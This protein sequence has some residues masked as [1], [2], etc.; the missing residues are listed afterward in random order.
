[1]A[2][3]TNDFE[4]G[5]SGTAVS[6]AN[7]AGGPDTQWDFVQIGAGA[8]NAYD[9]TRSAHGGLSVQLATPATA[10]SAYL[11]WSSTG[12]LPG[13]AGPTNSMQ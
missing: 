7:S 12:H 8:T 11:Q 9:N 1:M 2:Q 10:T 6:T 5:S 3:V 4:T 13:G